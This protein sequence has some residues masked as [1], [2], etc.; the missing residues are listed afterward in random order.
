MA[1][2]DDNFIPPINSL[3]RTTSL[4]ELCPDGDVVLVVEG[5]YET[6]R[7]TVSS[8][9]L[10]LASKVLKIYF[11][12]KYREG[13][14]FA[15]ED[16]QSPLEIVLQEDI[17]E[18][19]LEL[20]SI[21]HHQPYDGGGVKDVYDL[22]VMVDKYDCSH[23]IIYY[24]ETKLSWWESKAEWNGGLCDLRKSQLIAAAY[25]FNSAWYFQR[26]TSWLV[27][28][29]DPKVKPEPLLKR[30]LSGYLS[31]KDLSK[32]RCHDIAEKDTDDSTLS[33]FASHT[34]STQ[35]H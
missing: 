20:C 31:E 33:M 29:L 30:M 16:R 2:E 10:S 13:V 3:I 25:L 9:V 18:A 17:P 11:T 22:A 12:P 5:K 8:V 34:C 21:L 14:D 4:H 27:F 32:L 15:R 24:A 28:C 23:A 6:M 19:M 1:F 26:F 35:A 7:I